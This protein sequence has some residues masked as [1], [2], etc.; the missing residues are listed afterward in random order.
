MLLLQTERLPEGSK[1]AYELKLDGYRALAIK[2]GGKEDKLEGTYSVDG[3]KI[4]SVGPK[5]E[6]ETIKIKK[7]TDTELVTES[8]TETGIVTGFNYNATGAVK[9]V[10]IAKPLRH[11]QKTFELV[12][13][14]LD[15]IASERPT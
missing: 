10:L 13:G 9:S 5:G 15:M 1:W 4:E 3:D 11:G 7:L 8:E 14:E 6:K 12:V 2:A